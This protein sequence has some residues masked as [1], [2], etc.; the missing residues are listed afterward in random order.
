MSNIFGDY[1]EQDLEKH[2]TMQ[3]LFYYYVCANTKDC[4]AKTLGRFSTKNSDECMSQ[5]PKVPRVSL[6]S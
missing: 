6:Q 2:F 5:L 4:I 3:R 1:K